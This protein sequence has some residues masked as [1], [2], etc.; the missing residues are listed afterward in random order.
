MQKNIIY[1]S[2]NILFLFSLL[3]TLS[4]SA[5]TTQVGS[6]SYTNSHPGFDAAGRNGFPSGAP[7]LSGNAVGKPVPTN[8]WWSKLIKENHADN[9]FNYPMTMKT[10]NTGLIVTY[11]PWG[12]IGDSAPIEVGLTGLNTTKTTVSDYTDWTMTMN[13]KDSNHE[14]K[15]TSG[16]GMPFLYFEKEADDIVQIKVNSGSAS[17]LNEILTVENAAGGA[18]FAFYAPSGSTWVRAGTVFTSTLNGKDYWSMAM[19]PQNTSNVAATVQDLKK[20]AYVFPKNTS[21]AWSYNETTS[22]VTTTFTV[23]TDVKEG[24]NSNMLLGLLPHQWYHLTSN[25]PTPNT[26]A[27]T[28]VRGDLK[29]LDGNNFTVENTYKGILPTIPYLANYSAG[30]SPADLDTKISQI[31]NDGLAT[32]TDSYNEGQVMNRLIQTARIANQTGDFEA[33]DKMIAT[34]KER[35]EDWLTHESGEVA[36]LFYYNDA[37]SALL[38]YPAGHGQDNNLNDHHFHWGYFIH[39]AAFMEQFEPGWASKWGDM[40]NI[41]IRDAASYDRNDAQFP[42]LRNFSP[43]AGHSWANGF[44]TF[45]QGNDQEST[46]ESMQFASSLIHWGTITENKTIRDLGIYIYTTEQTAVEEYWFDVYERNFKPNQQYSLVS[47]VWGNSYDNGTFWT[48]DIAASYGIEMYPIHG[49]SFY[50]GHHQEYSKK[51]W[52]E[53]TR[54]TGVLSREDNDNLWHDTYWKYLSFTNP[55]E[56]V[57]LYNAYP[58]R[59][60]KFGI[61]D[62]QTYHWLHGVNAM[63][64]VDASI[65]ANYPIAVVFKQNGESTYVAHN[66]SDSEIV[67]AFSDGFQLTVPANQMKTSRDIA[68]SGVLSADFKQAFPN[69]SVNL[70]ASITG[71]GITKVEFFDGATSIGEA[72][73]A[74]YQLKATNLTLGVHGFYAKV[75]VNDQFNVTNIVNVQV[76]EQVPYSG[77]AI[78]IPGIIEPGFYDQFEGGKGQNITY[79]D[80]SIGNNG[81]FRTQENVDAIS[82]NGEGATVGWT[83]AGEWLEYTIDVQ[84]AGV[85]DVSFRAASGNASGGGPFYFEIE[86]K[87]VSPSISVPSSGDWEN[88][89]TNSA[90]DIELTKGKHVLRL[91]IESGEFNLGNMTFSY[92]SA[93]SFVPPV[94]NA[95]ENVTVILPN[96]TAPLNGSLSNDE[97]G[98]PITYTW[99]QV[100]GPTIIIFDDTTAA[101]P[102]ISNL[103]DGV[104][105]CKLTVSDGTYSSFDEVLI[106]VSAEGNL[107]PSISITSPNNGA[108]F[109]EGEVISITTI[110]N[111]LDGTIVLVEFF[112]GATKIGED[113]SA[114]FSFNWSD[115]ILGNHEITAIAADNVGAKTTSETVNVIISEEKSCAEISTEAQQGSFSNGYEVNFETIGTNVTITFKL[116]DTNKAGVVAYLWKQSPFSETSMDQIDAFTFAKTISGFTIGETIN[117]ACKFAYSGGLAATKYFSYEVGSS[118]T[119]SSSDTT[120]P[121]NFA[122][123][124]GNTTASSVEILLNATDDSGK[125]SYVISYGNTTETVNGDSGVQKSYIVNGLTSETSYSFSVIAKDLSGNVALNNPIILEAKTL[126]NSNSEC[127]GT[128]SDATQGDFLAGYTYNFVTNGSN[129]T[130]TFELLDTDK[131]DV[132]A[133]LWRQSPFAETSMS[134]VSGKK[135]SQTISGVKNGQ[136]ISYA[137]K[138]AFAGGLAVTKYFSYTVGNTCALSIENAILK[139]SVRLYP[140]PTQSILNLRSPIKTIT[141]VEIYSVIGKKVLEFNRNLEIVSIEELSIGLYLIK[142]SSD[143]ASYTTKFIKE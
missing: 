56:A 15:A 19:L 16:I 136:T 38:G 130:I 6:G 29:M 129:V 2:K 7:Q 105:K 97:E 87:K 102:N 61:S 20:Y 32:W 79:V 114:P 57:N 54:N 122:A 91:F 27:Y 10:T 109:K 76:G 112:D 119:G 108:A 89:I 141:K 42:F 70:M 4:T 80:N 96:T 143:E 101:S 30:F 58:E 82:L 13:W 65:T 135:F 48:A 44:A 12:V 137:C 21:T 39:A 3:I 72:T 131:S 25:S 66:Y 138:F 5:Q 36:F 47:R 8:D 43:Y 68:V 139:Q 104:Y 126:S 127:S 59:N 69:G 134:A 92:K 100:Y 140:N 106:L 128:E 93:L 121:E 118:C 73:A 81:D 110:A 41:L 78:S 63:G 113:T 55:Q 11:I 26:H 90:S 9:L 67:V 111:D 85:Y 46:S 75:F 24:T 45:P 99:E 123:S 64:I 34:V 37:W 95:G 125:V 60:L 50:L 94:A 18:D 51:L 77:T 86:G 14:L 120:A 132:D 23:D 28:S 49:G 53:I 17:I 103:E 88:W 31:E 52:S 83:G 62:A 117:Y 40:I 142:I 22:K 1:R 35:L 116:L 71:N 115:A 33:R 98:E 133:Y 107:S 84:T 124:T 74:P